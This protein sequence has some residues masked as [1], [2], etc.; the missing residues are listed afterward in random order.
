MSRRELPA[1]ARAYDAFECVSAL[2]KAVRRGEVDGALYWSMELLESG[3]GHWLWKRLR[4]IASEDVG[5]AAPPGTIA[6]VHALYDAWRAKPS[7]PSAGLFVGHAVILLAKSPKSQ[8]ATWATWHHTSDNVERRG[9]P[10][11]A[12]DDHTRRG[13]IL[14]RDTRFFLDEAANIEPSPDVD[15]EALE[16]I[17]KERVR[18]LVEGD[19]PAINPFHRGGPRTGQQA[20]NLQANERERGLPKPEGR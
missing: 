11:E 20:L 12:L 5:P 18:A 15:L 19:L 8:L 16:R 1:T 9:V 13:K 14:G 4:V 10:D 6:D 2:Q 7:D 17:Y 3:H